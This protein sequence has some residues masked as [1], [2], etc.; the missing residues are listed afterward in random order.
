MNLFPKKIWEV[1]L[2]FFHAV[3]VIGADINFCSVDSQYWR[4]ICAI[5]KLIAVEKFSLYNVV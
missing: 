2:P 3:V 1:I 5:R 4:L